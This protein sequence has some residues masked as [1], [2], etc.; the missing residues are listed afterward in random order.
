MKQ[1]ILSSILVLMLVATPVVSLQ[2]KSA[3]ISKQQAVDIAQQHSPGRVLSV[4][5]IKTKQGG[6]YRIKTLSP[7]GDIHI[8]IVDASSGTVISRH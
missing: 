5:R 4:S 7:S 8:I 1:T 6:A 2:A 3:G